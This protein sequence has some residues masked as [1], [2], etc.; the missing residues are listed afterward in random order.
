MEMSWGLKK[1]LAFIARVLGNMDPEKTREIMQKAQEEIGRQHPRGGYT[2]APGGGAGSRTGGPGH[3]PDGPDPKIYLSHGGGVNSWALYLYLMEQGE[4][5]G[6]D[7]EAV[8]VNHGTDWPETYEYMNMMIAKGY[9]VTVIR[10]E[11]G[12][13][14][15]IF[16]YYLKHKMIVMRS[17]R[18][19]TKYFKVRALI[20][21]YQYPCVELIGFDAGE[22]KRKLGMISKEGVAQDYPLIDAGIDRQGCIDIIKRHSLPL[23]PKSG[24]YICPFQGREQ[25]VE[26]KRKYPDLFCRATRLEKLTNERRALN[27]KKS[28]YFGD[29]PLETLVLPKDGEGYRAKVGQG[30]LIDPDYDKPPC[31]CGL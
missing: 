31:R 11:Y 2:A 6:V 1:R 17:P 20:K 22:Q 15:N 28:V 3:R 30:T 9:P 21:F 14:D 13:C 16:E 7:F 25:W 8:F 5:P 29:L 18:I 19:C 24:C 27:N 4:V 26:L 10:P 12:G 23:P